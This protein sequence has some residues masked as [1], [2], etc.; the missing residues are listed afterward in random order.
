MNDYQC[1][2]EP[3]QLR[4]EFEWAGHRIYVWSQTRR[5]TN[6]R[7][8]HGKPWIR[9]GVAIDKTDPQNPDIIWEDSVEQK[10]WHRAPGCCRPG[11][12]AAHQRPNWSR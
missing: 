2:D 9:Y 10:C 3:P 4:C 1:T 8:N 5:S 12:G 7:V 6:K 11:L